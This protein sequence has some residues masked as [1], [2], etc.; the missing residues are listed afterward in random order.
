[1][2][3][4]V[5]YVVGGLAQV[6]R[7]YHSNTPIF[8]VILFTCTGVLAHSILL[9]P[10]FITPTGIDVGFLNMFTL[11][12]WMVALLT[13][14]SSFKKPVHNLLV[15]ALPFAALSILATLSIPEGHVILPNVSSGL[16]AHILLSVLAYSVLI[17]AATQAGLLA[18]Q[19]QHLR[20]KK[21]TLMIN[22]LPPMQTMEKLL[23]E[24]LWI[25]IILLTLAILTG[26]Y[27]IDNI[28]AQH[29]AHKTVLT[30]MAWLVFAI[31]LWGHHIKGWRGRT[32]I[33]L[34]LTAFFILLLAYV[35]SS[36]VLQFVLHKL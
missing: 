18:C 14:L 13:L 27:Y 30:I 21:F 2:L 28:F 22:M 24:M 12:G 6:R 10:L 16:L 35:G 25:G 32:A 9:Y 7:I 20:A 8:W 3:A 36:I 34:T 33:N 23:F 5:A 4:I 26:A 17:L 19:D 29:I 15:L 1:V 31:L 11:I